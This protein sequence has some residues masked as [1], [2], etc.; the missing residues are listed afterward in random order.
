VALEAEPPPPV[1]EERN[2]TLK[3][4]KSGLSVYTVQRAISH[5]MIHPVYFGKRPM[6]THNEYQRLNREGLGPI[7]KGYRA[8]KDRPKTQKAAHRK[9][10]MHPGA[11]VDELVNAQRDQR[12]VL[13]CFSLGL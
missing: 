3:A 8:K 1:A 6:I 11:L 13:A 5:Q 7:P 4:A 12:R 9:P 2:F 10:E